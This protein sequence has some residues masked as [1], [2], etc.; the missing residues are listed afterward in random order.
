MTP[1]V[2]P[3]DRHGKGSL[4]L[5]GTRGGWQIKKSSRVPNDHSPKGNLLVS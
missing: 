3:L 2:G 1:N 4:H 5:R